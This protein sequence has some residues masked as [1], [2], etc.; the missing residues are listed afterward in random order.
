[1]APL[2]MI[3]PTN[4]L[5]QSDWLRYLSRLIQDRRGQILG[6][7]CS[8]LSW[9]SMSSPALVSNLVFATAVAA[10]RRAWRCF[11]SIGSVRA[12]GR[13]T[14]GRWSCTL[15]VATSPWTCCAW[16]A[17]PEPEPMLDRRRRQLELRAWQGDWTQH[18]LC[19]DSSLAWG[20]AWWCSKSQV[21]PRDVDRSFW[22]AHE[23]FCFNSWATVD[24][25]FQLKH[26][27]KVV[28]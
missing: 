28:G 15:L 25:L 22:W 23:A 11:S 17:V 19:S 10:E 7:E 9:S 27:G 20:P 26:H 6:S 18:T 5:L 21:L 12:T 3:S 14:C 8:E 16:N 13:R 24:M 2:E 4:L 1:M